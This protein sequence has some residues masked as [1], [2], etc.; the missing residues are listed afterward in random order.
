MD[1]FSVVGENFNSC[2]KYLVK[3]LERCIKMNLLLNWEKCYFMVKEGIVL[4][5]KI[6]G[7]V[8]QVDQLKLKVIPKI[9]PLISVKGIYYFLRHAGF[10]RY[11]IKDFSKIAQS[12]YKLLEK[13]ENLNLMESVWA[14]NFLKKKL[15]L[16][17]N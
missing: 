1:D 14:F 11:F 4:G 16:S 9:P 3:V 8:I 5:L 15:L 17:P 7:Q 6:L 13:K 10:D 2:I 12:V